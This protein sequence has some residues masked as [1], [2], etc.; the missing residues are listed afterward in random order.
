MDKGQ[1]NELFISKT[2]HS[3]CRYSVFEWTWKYAEHKRFGK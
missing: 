1:W 2:V 3:I